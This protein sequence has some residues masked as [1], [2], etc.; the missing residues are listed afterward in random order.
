MKDVTHMI[1]KVTKTY[2]SY[3]ALDLSYAFLTLER[4]INQTFDS[5]DTENIKDKGKQEES[6][7]LRVIPFYLKRKGSH[8]QKTGTYQRHDF[9]DCCVPLVAPRSSN[10]NIAIDRRNS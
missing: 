8:V 9:F 5:Y 10:I 2:L 1:R 4:N 3:L 7:M 6:S